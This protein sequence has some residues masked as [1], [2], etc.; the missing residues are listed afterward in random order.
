M[1]D[2]LVACPVCGTPGVHF[3][4]FADGDYCHWWECPSCGASGYT[5]SGELSSRMVITSARGYSGRVPDPSVMFVDCLLPFVRPDD[6]C[7]LAWDRWVSRRVVSPAGVPVG[8]VGPDGGVWVA[9]N[10]IGNESFGW[11]FESADDLRS[12]VADGACGVF[13]YGAYIA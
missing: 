8:V 9:R 1:I 12:W 13:P 3:D 4:E 10:H 2:V 6:D 5:A 11:L 7:R